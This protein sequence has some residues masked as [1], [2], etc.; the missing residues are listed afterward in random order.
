MFDLKRKRP[1]G[2]PHLVSFGD[3]RL[4]RPARRFHRQARFLHEFATVK[5]KDQTELEREFVV[6]NSE[7]LRPTVRGFGYW[8]W[9]PQV[10]L[11]RLSELPE[12][13]MLFYADV[14]FHINRK[15]KKRFRAWVTQF[16]ASSE[17][18]LVFQ[19]TPPEMFLNHDGRRLPSLEDGLWCKGDLV[20]FM[21]M[22][23]HPE[24]WTPTIGAGLFAVK[25]TQ[26]ARSFL[27][28]W[29]GFAE[30]HFGL[31]DDTESVAPN[32]VGFRE[33]RHDQSFFSLWIKKNAIGLRLSAYEYWYPNKNGRGAD[34]EALKRSPFLAKRDL[35]PYAHVTY[36]YRALRRRL[37][38][39][40]RDLRG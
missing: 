29:R 26:S 39:L 3:S 9:K 2:R 12:N 7:H 38:E 4:R 40:V 11:E 14:G 15:G 6:R 31:I 1:I 34:W 23:D 19:A 33:H 18:L 35:G 27:L 32:P 30:Q 13:S 28:E 8:I 37:S 20:D 25:N 36:R 17:W 24:L 5:I 21:G 16:E 10:V 22:R